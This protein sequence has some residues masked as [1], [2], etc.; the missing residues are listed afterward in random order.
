MESLHP[1]DSKSS[2]DH[3]NWH[4]GSNS[5]ELKKKT[6]EA[7]PRVTVLSKNNS[8]QSITPYDIYGDRNELSANKYNMGCKCGMGTK[9]EAKKSENKSR[10]VNGYEP[11]D[12]PWMIFIEI[13]VIFQN[14]YN[15]KSL[16]SLSFLLCKLGPIPYWFFL[17]H[18][19]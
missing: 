4:L 15:C 5:S 12:R 2:L 19:L 1:S 11:E 3:L 14:T 6:T 17:W 7:H 8:H 13:K 16:R 18:F 10:I 9:S